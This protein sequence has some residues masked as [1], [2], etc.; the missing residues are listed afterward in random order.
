MDSR[1]QRC[2][3]NI[4]YLK[5]IKGGM[6]ESADH[7]CSG[8]GCGHLHLA[9]QVITRMPRSRQGLPVAGSE[10][11]GG[12]EDGAVSRHDPGIGAGWRLSQGRAEMRLSTGTLDPA[13]PGQSGVQAAGLI[14]ESPKR[15]AS[16]IA[17][18]EVYGP[19]FARR[20]ITKIIAIATAIATGMSP[21]R[22]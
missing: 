9:G 15:R 16:K 13:T 8:G 4:R 2:I 21:D 20:R 11:L 1:P 14:L 17:N 18:A 10:G 22:A 5:A 7:G 6:D 19:A 12:G 3:L